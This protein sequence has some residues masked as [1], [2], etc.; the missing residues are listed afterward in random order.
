LKA[1][2]YLPQSSIWHGDIYRHRRYKRYIGFGV[3]AGSNLF[4]DIFKRG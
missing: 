4:I 1:G 3:W 2:A